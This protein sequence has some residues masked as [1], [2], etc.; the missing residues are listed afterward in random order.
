MNRSLA[1]KHAKAKLQNVEAANLENSKPFYDEPGKHELAAIAA[2]YTGFVR[3]PGKSRA[4]RLTKFVAA[5]DSRT[6]VQRCAAETGV[7][8]LIRRR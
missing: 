3:T 1:A 6:L 8:S 2:A 4:A 5:S 7:Y